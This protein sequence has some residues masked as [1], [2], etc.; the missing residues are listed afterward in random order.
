MADGIRVP[1]KGA[2]STAD[3]FLGVDST[4]TTGLLAEGALAAQLKVPGKIVP[5][6]YF[7]PIALSV[8][9][10][11]AR[12]DGAIW[13]TV[14]RHRYVEDS[15]ATERYIQNGAGVRL[16]LLPDEEGRFPL[17][18]LGVPTAALFEFALSSG[19][20]VLVRKSF[21]LDAEVNAP[22]GTEISVASGVTISKPSGNFFNPLGSF[23]LHQYGDFVGADDAAVVMAQVAQTTEVTIINSGGMCFNIRLFVSTASASGLSYSEIDTSTDLI[24]PIDIQNPQGICTTGS[25]AGPLVTF[26]Y[27]RDAEVLGGHSD[28]YRHG[29]QAWGGDSNFNADGVDFNAE[30]KCKNISCI[31]FTGINIGSSLPFSGGGGWASMVDGLKINGCH[32]EPDESGGDVGLDFEG[33]FN[34]HANDNT[35]KDFKNGLCSTFFGCR[36]CSFDGNTGIQKMGFPVYRTYNSSANPD[37]QRTIS[38]KNN[39]FSAYGP[40]DIGFD[41]RVAYAGGLSVTETTCVVENGTV[42][43]AKASEAPFTSPATF[44][45]AQWNEFG[46]DA[47]AKL[48]ANNGTI[49]GYYQSGNT[50]RNIITF[51]RN[52]FG[53]G[54]Q[55]EITDDKHF[56]DTWLQPAGEQKHR[57]TI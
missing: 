28:G 43:T 35:V 56:F 13:E 25:S 42:Y 24:G 6:L 46:P 19:A 52:S 36:D 50:L 14:E 7:D 11:A 10:E 38:V 26:R 39:V 37:K 33:C 32:F 48:D 34:A 4:G 55:T 21:T 15:A 51:R 31:G 30:R 17:D 53:S 5:I 3:K 27:C 54:G 44:D 40:E 23:K 20:H 29:F 1:D 47:Y 9:S 49:D 2:L 18:G 8:A 57:T 45:P 16:R 22:D 12:G 41:D